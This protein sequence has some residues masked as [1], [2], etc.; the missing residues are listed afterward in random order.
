MPS[1]A[2]PGGRFRTKA[3]PA[4]TVHAPVLGPEDSFKS[5]PA[6]RLMKRRRTRRTALFFS[7]SILTRA[8][9]V[10]VNTAIFV[11]S[12]FVEDPRYSFEKKFELLEERFLVFLHLS[13]VAVG[14]TSWALLSLKEE[15]R[16]NC[17]KWERSQRTA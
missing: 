17:E 10:F 6:Q 16:R 1:R 11:V 8:T 7:E 2:R 3:Q 9:V 4:R 14:E 5:F 15:R 13:L 12:V